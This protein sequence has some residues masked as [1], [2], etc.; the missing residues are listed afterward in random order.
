MDSDGLTQET[1]GRGKD[2]EPETAWISAPFEIL[3]AGRDPQGRGWGKYL[4]F[5]DKDNRHHL[6]VVSDA[7]L[8][9][10]P[11]ALCAGLARAKA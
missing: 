9:G 6:R 7:A 11:A 8:H 1:K 4:R 2:A 5:L 10:D 3:G